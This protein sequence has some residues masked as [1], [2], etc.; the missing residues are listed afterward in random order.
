MNQLVTYSF[1][2]HSLDDDTLQWMYMYYGTPRRS[3][4]TFFELT[5]SGGWPN[6]AR[7]LVEEVNSWFAL[8]WAVYVFLVI[9]AM[10]RIVSALF[11]KDTLQAAADDVEKQTQRKLCNVFAA[12]DTSG[13]GKITLDEFENF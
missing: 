3:L 8:F 4:W 9:F 1:D 11:L 13:D 5:F 6:Y 10:T 12:A 2:G 7:R